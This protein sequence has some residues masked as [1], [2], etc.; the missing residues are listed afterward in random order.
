MQVICDYCNNPAQLVDGGVIYPHLT[1]FREKGKMIPVHTRFFWRCLPCDAYVGTHK[2]SPNRQP[3]GRLANA[4]LRRAKRDAHAIFDPLWKLKMMT[5][6]EA[7]TWLARTLNI[8]PKDC[9]IG[10]FSVEQCRRTI[11]AITITM[12]NLLDIKKES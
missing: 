4:E 7:Y 5:R 12:H 8:E 6:S 11:D 10:M 1:Y 2:D 9:H 3:L